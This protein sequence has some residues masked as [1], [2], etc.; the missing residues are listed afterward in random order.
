[1]SVSWYGGRIHQWSDLSLS[2]GFRLGDGVF[3]TLRT[4]NHR[5]FL[6]HEHAKRLLHSG[7]ALGFLN[8]P[9]AEI[10]ETEVL[11][12]VRSSERKPGPELIIRFALFNDDEGWGFS[13]SS[14]EL[15]QKDEQNGHKC[16][17]V[18]YS[19]YPHPGQ[20]LIPPGSA[21]Q[22]K[23][24]SRG[25]LAHALREAK[26]LG[27]DEALLRN[28]KGE[29]VEGTRS[30]VFVV[31]GRTL[32]APGPRSMALPGITREVVVEWAESQEVEILDQPVPAE[33]LESAD[34][35]FLTSSLLGVAPVCAIANVPVYKSNF[36]KLTRYLEE[37]YIIKSAS[38]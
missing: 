35:I 2:T 22:V 13:V 19:S 32:F 12:H 4:Y 9:G 17:R 8:L 24:L 36:G 38:S 23:W 37:L 28:G 34:E 33:S 30:N 11:R 18:G 7:S 14:E 27:W 31:K 25:P 21:V 16:L 20:Y 5:P 3:E 26:G 1:M 6:L 29:V 10:V 15:A